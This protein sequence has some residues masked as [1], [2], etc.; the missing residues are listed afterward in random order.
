MLNFAKV[1]LVGGIQLARNRAKF[2][3]VSLF[4][5]FV[6]PSNAALRFLIKRAND[7]VLDK[8]RKLEAWQE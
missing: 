8:H 1:V 4:L 3:I 7:S 5:N 6:L 2:E